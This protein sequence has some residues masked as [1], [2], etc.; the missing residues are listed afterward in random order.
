MGIWGRGENWSTRWWPENANE[1]FRLWPTLPFRL[2]HLCQCELTVDGASFWSVGGTDTLLAI[3]TCLELH[4]T[5]I[6]Y[7]QLLGTAE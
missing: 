4:S 5:L 2:T 6:P 3:T 7:A 1:S